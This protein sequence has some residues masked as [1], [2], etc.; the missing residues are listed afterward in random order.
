MVVNPEIADVAEKR[1]ETLIHQKVRSF[2]GRQ[3]DH[4]RQ[5][6]VV[7]L[8]YNPQ[9]WFKKDAKRS[10]TSLAQI[11]LLSSSFWGLQHSHQEQALSPELGSE[12]APLD[13]SAS[14]PRYPQLWEKPMDVGGVSPTL[15]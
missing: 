11:L 7:E 12:M 3:S 13:V 9:K 14:V 1:Q 2:Q 5:K 10:V 15:W 4:L 8:I 6:V